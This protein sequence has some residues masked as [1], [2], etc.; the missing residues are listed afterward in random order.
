MWTLMLLACVRRETCQSSFECGDDEICD[1]G[2]CDAALGRN[3]DVT[4]VAAAVPPTY[5]DSTESWDPEDDSDPDLF[6][7]FGME[8]QSGCV[9]TQVPNS[10]EPY[11]DQA[12]PVAIGT[13]GVFLVNLYD[14]DADVGGEA[15]FGYGIYWEGTDRLLELVRTDGLE[16][17]A[18]DETGEASVSLRLIP[19]H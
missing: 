9:T 1:A 13:D 5:P 8:D 3:Y 10:V 15:D 7:E 17:A 14:D 2:V 6:A 16:F 19:I 18:Q 4:I 12:C 11:W